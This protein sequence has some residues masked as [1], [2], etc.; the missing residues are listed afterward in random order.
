MTPEGL[1]RKPWR[2]KPSAR[3]RS[4]TC[5]LVILLQFV[6]HAQWFRNRP[7]LPAE[8]Q[9]A[10]PKGFE[11]DVFTFARVRY[12]S[13]RLYEGYGRGN[14]ETDWPDAELNL[15][16]RLQQMTSLRCHPE[17]QIV[18]L[19]SESL[20]H[21]PFIYIVE[22]GGLQF[23][24]SELDP[25]RRYLLNGGFLMMDDF[26]GEAEWENAAAELKRV[27]PDREPVE[28]PLDHEI[29]HMVFDLKEKPQLPSIH[30]A[31][32]NRG[33]PNESYERRDASQVHYRAILDDQKRVMVMMC[34]NTDLGDGWEREG[35]S[36]WYFR[37]YSEK[38]GYPM[39]INIIFYAMTH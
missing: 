3:Q 35:E 13:P 30:H 18:N 38:K 23:L 32:R 14:Y 11:S 17:G 24:D 9:W 6:D 34:H 28:L 20:R 21:F 8:P 37:E 29:F 27:F 7:Q 31:A 16:Y 26:W 12:E 39:G 25:L 2:R 4:L 1:S 22:P 33:R 15:V 10:L 19:T 5:A 36:E